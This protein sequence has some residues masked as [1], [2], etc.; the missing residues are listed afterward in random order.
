MVVHRLTGDTPRRDL[1]APEWSY[2]KRSIL[3]GIYA[4]LR[5][6]GTYQGF[7]SPSRPNRI[8]PFQTDEAVHTTL[9][10]LVPCERDFFP[11]PETFAEVLLAAP[12]EIVTEDTFLST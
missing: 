8:S 11:V 9:N 2:R 10:V 3:N 12:A 7:R 6:R 5:K 4:E 1:I